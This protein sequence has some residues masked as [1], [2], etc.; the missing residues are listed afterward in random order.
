MCSQ[1][2]GVS[3]EAICGFLRGCERPARDQVV[4]NLRNALRLAL[5][6]GDDGHVVGELRPFSG[7]IQGTKLSAA[8]ITPKSLSG[9]PE[10]AGMVKS[11]PQADTYGALSV[12]L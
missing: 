11:R 8:K 7:H 3:V 12:H 10:W 1:L 6:C 9:L 2:H 5:H 4:A